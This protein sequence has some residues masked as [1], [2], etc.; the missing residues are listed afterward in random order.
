MAEQVQ[1]NEREP[2]DALSMPDVDQ[3]LDDAYELGMEEDDDTWREEHFCVWSP[4]YKKICH[5]FTTSSFILLLLSHTHV[6]DVSTHLSKIGFLP[7]SEVI[8]ETL[9]VVQLYAPF[10]V[11]VILSVLQSTRL[12]T[13]KTHSYFVSFCTIGLQLSIGLACNLAQLKEAMEGGQTSSQPETTHHPWFRQG[14]TCDVSR[15]GLT[16][17]LLRR[18]AFHVGCALIGYMGI[19]FF[20]PNPRGAALTMLAVGASNISRAQFLWRHN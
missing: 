6:G 4:L 12:Y 5:F 3:E 16:A 14:A 15:D 20:L 1:A 10:A 13:H 8:G 11:C 18:V 9:A 17:Q 2:G 19:G 7:E